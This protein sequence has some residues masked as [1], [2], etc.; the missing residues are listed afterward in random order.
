M[1]TA[2]NESKGFL[3]SM[4]ALPVAARAVSPAHQGFPSA[5]QRF[6]CFPSQAMLPISHSHLPVTTFFLGLP[7]SLNKAS[8]SSSSSHHF[9]QTA[10]IACTCQ[11]KMA[12]LCS[13]AA[14][15]PGSSIYS[16][17][18]GDSMAA[19]TGGEAQQRSHRHF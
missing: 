7:L 19:E 17:P 9:L 11:G 2:T 13:F 12:R 14:S 16:F 10:Q 15:G 6:P 3:A 8:C 4:W 5:S 1:D 18:F